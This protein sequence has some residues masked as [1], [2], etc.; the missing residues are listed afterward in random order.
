MVQRRFWRWASSTIAAI[1]SRLNEGFQE[2]VLTV[3]PPVPITLTKSA[4]CLT[5]S[6]TFWRTPSMPSASPPKYQ[7]W[8]PVMV[9]GWPHSTSRAPRPSP[10]SKARRSSNVV[11]PRPPVSRTVVMPASSA[12]WAACADEATSTPSGSCTVVS[13]GVPSPGR[14]RW[15]WVSIRPGSRVAPR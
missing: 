7:V 15:T 13:N 6:R 1:S 8:P 4:P 3:P 10:S 14:L 9:I 2:I 5:T 12:I 11:V